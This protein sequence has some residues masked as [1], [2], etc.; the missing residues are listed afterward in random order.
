M[1]SLMAGRPPV[2]EVIIVLSHMIFCLAVDDELHRCTSFEVLVLPPDLL[3]SH[4]LAECV[5]SDSEP[6][7]GAHEKK[8]NATPM[9]PQHSRQLTRAGNY[10]IPLMRTGMAAL[11]RKS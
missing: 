11:G 5:L 9:K 6:S 1:V 10:F 3:L 2:S 8:E 7:L 4:S